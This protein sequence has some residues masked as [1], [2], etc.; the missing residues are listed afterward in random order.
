MPERKTSDLPRSYLSSRLTVFS[1]I[2]ALP[3]PT[4]LSP[5][6]HVK[7]GN[8]P[9]APQPAEV[10]GNWHSRRRSTTCQS[11]LSK[12]RNEVVPAVG[13]RQCC[14]CT[15]SW[16]QFHCSPHRQKPSPSLS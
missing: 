12:E 15:A 6:F 11:V 8:G 3:G 2:A 4:G 14:A 7:F 16:P 10:G 1:V 13:D 9:N 5:E